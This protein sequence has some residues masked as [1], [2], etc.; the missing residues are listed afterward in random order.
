M[1]LPRSAYCYGVKDLDTGAW[2]TATGTSGELYVAGPHLV[3]GYFRRNDGTVLADN[4]SRDRFLDAPPEMWPAVWRQPP[5]LEALR[6][7]EMRRVMYRTGDLVKWRADGELDHMGRADSQVKVNGV[8]VEL[9]HVSS[10]SLNCYGVKDA[11]AIAV[12][13][14]MSKTKIVLI[15]SPV[16]PTDA[17]MAELATH[18]PRVYMPA[19]AVTVPKLPTLPNGKVDRKSLKHSLRTRPQG[20]CA[21]RF[22]QSCCGGF[23]LR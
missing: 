12:Q 23:R 9:G 3:Q 15:A 16:V 18:L 21:A 14:T 6:P 10:T 2:L 8:R 1:G 17:L 19:A 11:R 22:D 5:D 7:R 4:A 13:D 20:D